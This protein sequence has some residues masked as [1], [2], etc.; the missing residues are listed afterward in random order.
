MPL[1]IDADRRVTICPRR[2]GIM[3]G[4]ARKPVI[5]IHRR[6]RNAIG[7]MPTRPC[8]CHPPDTGLAGRP[9]SDGWAGYWEVTPDDNPIVGP[10]GPEIFTRSGLQRTACR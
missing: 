2:D 7:R 8:A 6:W 5:R 10:T 4:S 1:T 9:V 3:V